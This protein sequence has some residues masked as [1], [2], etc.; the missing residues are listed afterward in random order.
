MEHWALALSLDQT[1]LKG[2]FFVTKIFLLL[3]FAQY[4]YVYMSLNIQASHKN[5]CA[6][7][8]KE[9][10]FVFVKRIVYNE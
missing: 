3:N 9:I 4:L 2:C 6:Q 10:T 7:P 8:L 1:S 5:N